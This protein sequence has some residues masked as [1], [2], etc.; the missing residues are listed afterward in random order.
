MGVT[1]RSHDRRD[2]RASNLEKAGLLQR[3]KYLS[4]A[5]FGNSYINRN[6]YYEVVFRV[7]FRVVFQWCSNGVPMAERVGTPHWRNP[8]QDDFGLAFVPPSYDGSFW[9]ELLPG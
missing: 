8:S 4:T 7:V 3:R 9:Q 2:E 5:A 1:E 6:I